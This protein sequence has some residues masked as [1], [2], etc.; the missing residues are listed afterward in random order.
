MNTRQ[1]MFGMF[2][3]RHCR[4]ER[5][6]FA[7]LH[8]MIEAKVGAPVEA[9]WLTSKS[10]SECECHVKAPSTRLLPEDEIE[11]LPPSISGNV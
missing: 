2:L 6:R 3:R 1:A 8:K 10:V 4:A 11:P 5:S 7:H 9:R